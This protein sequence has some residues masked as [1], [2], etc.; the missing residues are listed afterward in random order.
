M[1]EKKLITTEE[2]R[3]LRIAQLKAKLQKE[4]ARLNQD[5]R[6]ERNGQLIAFGV[7]VEEIFKLGDEKIIFSLTEAAKT[8]L[9]DRNLHRAIAGFERLKEEGKKAQSS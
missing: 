9:K 1:E 7:L 5:K 8:R 2:K 6:K 4:E 3:K